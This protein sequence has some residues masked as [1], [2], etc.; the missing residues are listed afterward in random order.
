[1][2]YCLRGRE[3]ALATRMLVKWLQDACRPQLD[4]SGMT[5]VFLC[6]YVGTLYIRR[7]PV[8]S[9]GSE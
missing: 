4:L 3:L 6:R 8:D 2:W 1:M 9:A 7:V 5:V